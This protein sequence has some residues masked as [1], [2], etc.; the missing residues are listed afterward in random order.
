MIKPKWIDLKF[1]GQKDMRPF[2]CL[3]VQS[4]NRMKHLIWFVGLIALVGCQTNPGAITPTKSIPHQKSTHFSKA[5]N[6]KSRD[7]AP[8]GPLPT[9]FKTVKPVSEPL[10]RYGNPGDYKI[11]GH[12]YEVMTNATGYRARGIASWYGTKFHSGRTSSGE[13]YDM[14]AL[15]AAHKTLPL[16]TYVRVKNLNNGRTAIV[17][18]NDRGPFHSGRVIDLSYAAAAKLGV[19]PKGTAPVEIE[20]LTTKAH[21]A[22]YYLQAGAFSSSSRAESFRGQLSKLTPSPVFIEKF[23]K[24]YIVRV[25]PFANKK[26]SDHL[27]GTLA[28]KGVKGTYS[29]LI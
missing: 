29:L 15:T 10:S 11:D 18:V 16:P 17:K 21:T 23:E 26:M 22:H 12:T 13:H 19:F 20:A 25:G 28:N 8:S 5:K 1:L 9:S 7:G 3:S 6:S 4:P 24:Q 2:S 14:Y 27:K